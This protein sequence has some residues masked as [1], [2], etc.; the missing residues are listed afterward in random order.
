MGKQIMGEDKKENPYGSGFEANLYNL[1]L[2]G[3][4]NDPETQAAYQQ[5]SSPKTNYDPSTGKTWQ[6]SAQ[7]P[8]VISDRFN[9]P[10]GNAPSNAGTGPVKVL[11][12]GKGD[13]APQ[14]M[15]QA[16]LDNSKSLRQA[17]QLSSMLESPDQAKTLGKQNMIP[18]VELMYQ[19]LSPES[20]DV[21]GLISALQ[22]MTYKTTSGQT[23]SAAEEKRLS[24]Y[25]PIV[26]DQPEVAKQKAKNFVKEFD[27][28]LKEQEALFKS[29]NYRIPDLPKSE[30]QTQAPQG[31]KKIRNTKT[32][33]EFWYNES[34]KE[35]IPV[36]Q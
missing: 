13:V 18:G 15:Q 8:K 6:V 28:I 12:E 16:Y 30:V 24:R 32:G 11:S 19:L 34:T 20:T 10:S 5:L 2:K 26:E 14:A 17:Q 22:S 25:V 35:M 9:A 31:T 29:S 23:V 3:D 1:A 27:T 7:V 33:Q 36:G 21:R 4:P